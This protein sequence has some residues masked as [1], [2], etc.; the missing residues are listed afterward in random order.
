MLTTDLAGATGTSAGDPQHPDGTNRQTQGPGEMVSRH[1]AGLQQAARAARKT[2]DELYL[3]AGLAAPP[4]RA[5]KKLTDII[6]GVLCGKAWAIEAARAIPEVEAV[7]QQFLADG[8][9]AFNGDDLP[10]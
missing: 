4:E 2:A 3:L 1:F 9:E 10:F 7:Y 6:A 8:Q 5:V